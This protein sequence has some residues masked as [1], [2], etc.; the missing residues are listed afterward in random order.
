METGKTLEES[1]DEHAEFLGIGATVTLPDG[2]HEIMQEYKE[3]KGTPCKPVTPEY[4]INELG[5]EAYIAL[6]STDYL[7]E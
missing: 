4:D 3:K 1:I 7:T 5:M 2:F 6:P